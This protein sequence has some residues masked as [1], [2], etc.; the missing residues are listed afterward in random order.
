MD[1]NEKRKLKYQINANK[2]QRVLILNNIFG[3]YVHKINIRYKIDTIINTCTDMVKNYHIISILYTIRSTF[4]IYINEITT[5]IKQNKNIEDFTT[6]KVWDII[7][8]M[9]KYNFC[10]DNYINHMKWLDRIEFGKEKK[11]NTFHN[12]EEYNNFLK[13]IMYFKVDFSDKYN[14]KNKDKLE[15]FG[16][17]SNGDVTSIIISNDKIINEQLILTIIAIHQTITSRKLWFSNLIEIKNIIRGDK[18]SYIRNT[19]PSEIYESAYNYMLY[20]Q[21]FGWDN[22]INLF[23]KI[24]Q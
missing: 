8:I 23:Q 15:F 17:I 9:K 18:I 5:V 20:I 10:C 6:T 2:I 16:A 19:F 22:F 24:T 13:S 14:F 3:N 11:Q 7:A 12:T 21:K 4:L 1:L